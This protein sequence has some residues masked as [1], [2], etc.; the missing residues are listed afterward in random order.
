MWNLF[1]AWLPLIFAWML[2]K[3]CPRGIF[4]S[5]TNF[6]WFTLWLLFLPNSFYLVTDFIH[7]TK[8]NQISLIFDVIL[9]TSYALTGL[10]LGFTSLL[11]VHVKLWQRL[12]NKAYLVVYGT[13]LLCGFAIYLGRFLR[14]NS[15]DIITNPLGLI[16]DVGIRLTNPTEHIFTFS[17]TLLFFVFLSVLYFVIWK[18][19][20]LAK[21]SNLL[22][23]LK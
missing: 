11:L 6:V 21:Q 1:L 19:V 16:F 7:L 8:T 2:A 9:L 23:M 18:A 13:L 15:W 17:A 20:F 22:K 14:W 3:R 5:W 12:K 4:W 10:I